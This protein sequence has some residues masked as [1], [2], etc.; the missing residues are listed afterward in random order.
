M[1]WFNTHSPILLRQQTGGFRT[2]QIF[3]TALPLIWVFLPRHTSNFKPKTK[4]KQYFS[5]QKECHVLSYLGEV[6]LKFFLTHFLAYSE[7]FKQ[8]CLSIG[9][10]AEVDDKQVLNSTEM[11]IQI[12]K[13]KMC[14]ASNSLHFYDH[15]KIWSHWKHMCD[16]W[17]QEV[18]LPADEIYCVG[19]C[20]PE[21]N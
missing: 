15:I 10:M 16:G 1:L 8:I 13:L 20:S 14:T 9:K 11:C 6:K 17:G 12:L 21:K 7:L 2:R 4:I 3:I 18:Q 19:L 5:S